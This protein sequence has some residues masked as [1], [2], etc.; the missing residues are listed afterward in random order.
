MNIQFKPLDSVDVEA[1]VTGVARNS[2][3]QPYKLL[4]GLV[5][6]TGT[7]KG[8]PYLLVENKKG[9]LGQSAWIRS[10]SG[11]NSSRSLLPLTL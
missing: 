5:G 2:T 7:S 3:V 4:T 8:R 11:I 1:R 6:K 9:D 10:S